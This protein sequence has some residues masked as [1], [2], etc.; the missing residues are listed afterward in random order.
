MENQTN[1]AE[2]DASGQ[3]LAVIAESLY[4]INL[5]LLPGLG[6]AALFW[7]WRKNADAPPLARNHL[8]Q[9]VFVSL[10]G[11]ILI[12]VFT[13]AFLLFGGLQW[14][15][16]WVLVIMYFVCVHASL[17]LC[18]MFGLSCAMAGKT[19]RFPLIGPRLDG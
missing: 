2:Q 17:V 7:L 16:T 15:W 19:F 6:F 12:A 11:G 5:L 10:W 1:R 14:K 13:A 4:L 18:G 9:T 8:R 3:S